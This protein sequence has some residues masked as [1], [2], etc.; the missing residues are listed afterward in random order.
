MPR[1]GREV[2]EAAALSGMSYPV[3][4]SFS[5]LL[6]VLTYREVSEAH[7]QAWDLIDFST[8]KAREKTSICFDPGLTLKL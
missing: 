4:M 7:T 2:F 1:C 8:K 5:L 3:M 6:E